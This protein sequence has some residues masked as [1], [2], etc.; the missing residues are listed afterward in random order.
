MTSVLTAAWTLLQRVRA[1]RLLQ[2]QVAQH[3]QLYDLPTKAQRA[4]PAVSTCLHDALVA[5]R[6]HGAV[7]RVSRASAF[8]CCVRT[9][10]GQRV[11]CSNGTQQH[12]LEPVLLS[13]A[14]A[15]ST[16]ALF[17]CADGSQLLAR[18][19][20]SP[21][22]LVRTNAAAP[23]G[24]VARVAAARLASDTA[25]ETG[26]SVLQASA[27]WCQHRATNATNATNACYK[28]WTS[29]CA[30][31][32]AHA[33]R[34][35]IPPS[36]PAVSFLKC[37]Y[38]RHTCCGMRGQHVT[39]AVWR[40]EYA[41]ATHRQLHCSAPQ[42]LSSGVRD[43]AA[44]VCAGES[45]ATAG[46]WMLPHQTATELKK[47][48]PRCSSD[49]EPTMCRNCAWQSRQCASGDEHAVCGNRQRQPPRIGRNA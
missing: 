22:V 42:Q 35:G 13:K 43:A 3:G 6:R 40:A 46:A 20:D 17:G 39:D 34:A 37:A 48:C 41:S 24:K 4:S 32:Q 12:E 36:G 2:K 28:C 47:I 19:L 21:H 25:A 29:A 45:L 49:R 30:A 38:E 9:A 14:V 7:T 5:K 15:T 11:D 18:C 27:T 23:G 26:M 16:P 1:C 31:M 10:H 44:V 8:G 33:L